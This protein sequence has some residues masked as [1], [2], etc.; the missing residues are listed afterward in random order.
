[1][2]ELID[3]QALLGKLWKQRQNYQMMDDTHTADK[4]MHGLYRAEQVV[5]DAPIIPAPR[6]V[7]CEEEMPKD[8][9]WVLVWGDGFHVPV[10][11]FR[12]HGAWLDS[13]FEKFTGVTHWMQLPEPPQEDA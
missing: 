1:M 10:E 4:I 6:W 12:E 11:V 7:R 8:G 5:K 13:Q 2:I 9:E 3:R